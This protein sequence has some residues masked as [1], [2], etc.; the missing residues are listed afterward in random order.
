MGT[1]AGSGD[2]LSIGG[3]DRTGFWGLG[4]SPR[5]L[6]D[7]IMGLLRGLEGIDVSSHAFVI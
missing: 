3:L 6:W 5:P 1:P 4:G 7:W 2:G